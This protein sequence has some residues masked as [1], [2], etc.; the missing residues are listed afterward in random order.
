[1][2]QNE[3]A[4]PPAPVKASAGKAPDT[5]APEDK[6]QNAQADAEMEA[7]QKKNIVEADSNA[8]GVAAETAPFPDEKG[9]AEPAGEKNQKKAETARPSAEPKAA[10]APVKKPAG[11]ILQAVAT[12]NADRALFARDDLAG[13]GYKSWISIGK[14]KESVFVVEAGEFASIKDAAQQKE[15]LEKAG[16]EP[17]VAQAGGKTALVAGVFQ[18]KAGADAVADRVKAVGFAPKV[19]SRK[20][21]SDLYLVRVGPYGSAEE[22]KKAGEAIKAAGYAPVSVIQ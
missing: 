14:V 2:D 15:K 13:K 1:M 7:V 6:P 19:I 17:R 3:S 21:P 18:D 12:S 20:E 16:F 4:K 5:K 8:P 9:E 11:L 22:A 10:Q